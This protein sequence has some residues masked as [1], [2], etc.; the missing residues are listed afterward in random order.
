MTFSLQCRLLCVVA[1]AALSACGGGGG[2]GI[3]VEEITDPAFNDM[4]VRGAGQAQITLAAFVDGTATVEK[5]GDFNSADGTISGSSL[6]AGQDIDT[7]AF[8]N[9]A[10]G[11]YSRI[12][13]I[14]GTTNIFGAVGLVG[15]V[16]PT[17]TVSFYNT[18]WVGMTASA[19]GQTYV[20]QGDASFTATWDNLELDGH[21]TNLS[22]TRSGTGTTEQD[23]GNQGSITLNNAMITDTDFIGGSVTGTGIFAG[24]GAGSDTAGTQGAFF[25]PL[26]DELGGIL[27]ILDPTINVDGAFQAD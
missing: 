8:T 17:G 22:G 9:P 26:G 21:F 16:P 2:S 23:V 15:T 1:F 20:L 27:R 12:V 7:A 24:L 25:G 14:S 6:L 4:S 3:E 10:S 13:Q 11:E 18:G 5:S 19:D